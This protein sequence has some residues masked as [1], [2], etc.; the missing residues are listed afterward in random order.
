[1]IH[2][3]QR[4]VGGLGLEVEASI[5]RGRVLVPV[6]GAVGDSVDDE[7][8]WLAWVL[9]G[10]KMR[11]VGVAR[12]DERLLTREVRVWDGAV[13]EVDLIS[14]EVSS[15]AA[16]VIVRLKTR[17]GSRWGRRGS[18][19]HLRLVVTLLLVFAGLLVAVGRIVRV[20]VGGWPATRAVEQ[21][22]VLVELLL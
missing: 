2:G 5:G 19:S 3:A 10:L 8:R 17:G 4:R 7:G 13:V 6:H 12:D 21:L 20:G 18:V 14:A 15:D 16:G 22:I 9:I 1:M 11:R